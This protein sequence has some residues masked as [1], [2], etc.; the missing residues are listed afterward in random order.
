MVSKGLEAV[1]RALRADQ[2]AIQNSFNPYPE[3]IESRL[4]Q[5]EN[6][7]D[8]LDILTAQGINLP[9]SKVIDLLNK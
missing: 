5:T 9:K 2:K 1:A 6:L 4:W 8:A 7:L 3:S